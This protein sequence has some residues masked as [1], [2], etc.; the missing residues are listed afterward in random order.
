MSYGD[1]YFVFTHIPQQ[2]CT[3]IVFIYIYSVYYLYIYIY[4]GAAG[5]QHG[6]IYIHIVSH[7]YL[8]S[9]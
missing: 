2:I 8:L 6:N 3:Y 1:M 5:T 4:G 9:P 7:S